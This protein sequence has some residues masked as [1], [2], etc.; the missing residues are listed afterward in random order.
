MVPEL[1]KPQYVL[2]MPENA[3]YLCNSYSTVCVWKG[4]HV[5]NINISKLRAG[6]KKEYHWGTLSSC[7][8]VRVQYPPEL[9]AVVHP[10]FYLINTRLIFP[11]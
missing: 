7:A 3:I 2:G 5:E 6:S 1:H 8:Q 10:C 4:F 9:E 11:L